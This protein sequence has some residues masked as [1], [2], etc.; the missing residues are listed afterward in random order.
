MVNPAAITRN[1][2]H[3]F[4]DFVVAGKSL[5]CEPEVVP[6]MDLKTLCSTLR[7]N[8]SSL[9]SR[10]GQFNS[11]QG[12]KEALPAPPKRTKHLSDREKELTPSSNSTLLL[13]STNVRRSPRKQLSKD[14][15]LSGGSSG[16]DDSSRCESNC[17]SQSDSDSWNR[18][19]DS[20]YDLLYKCLNLNPATRIS[21]ELA[22]QHSFIVDDR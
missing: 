17:A 3:S 7:T 6:V 22:L 1:S 13:P 11:K 10:T 2:Y 15:L 8:S 19:P 16:C 5:I 9:S 18:I 21:A 12:E 20:A 14:R 4:V